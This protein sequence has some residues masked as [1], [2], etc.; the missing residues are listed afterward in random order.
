MDRDGDGE[1]STKD[2]GVV[3]RAFGE[4][5][6][7]AELKN[8]IAVL[9]VGGNGTVDFHEFAARVSAGALATPTEEEARKVFKQLDRDGNGF[10][11]ADELRHFMIALGEQL[12]DGHVDKMI[13]DADTD[14]DGRISYDEF[15]ALL[16]PM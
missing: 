7:E 15:S 10:I 3:M 1:I 9:D 16:K 11:T 2:L 8:M 13:R 4:N 6:T 14:G 5:P 12:P